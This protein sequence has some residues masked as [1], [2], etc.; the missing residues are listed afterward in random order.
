MISISGILIFEILMPKL[1]E[2]RKPCVVT[3]RERRGTG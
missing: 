2:E 3:R 1:D